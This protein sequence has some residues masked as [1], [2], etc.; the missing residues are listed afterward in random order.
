VAQAVFALAFITPLVA[1]KFLMA[2]MLPLGLLVAAPL[3]RLTETRPVP[4]LACLLLL[5]LPMGMG[6]GRAVTE[7]WPAAQPLTH[8]GAYLEPLDPAERGLCRWIA[9][10]TPKEALFV[11]SR[12]TVPPFG[13]RRLFVGLPQPAAPPGTHD[14]WGMP[15]ELILGG[16]TGADTERA[17]RRRQIALELLAPSAGPANGILERLRAEAGGMPVYVI[18]RD[19]SVAARMT[20]LGLRPVYR[21]P[22]EP[23]EPAVFLVTAPARS[24]R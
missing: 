15:P 21:E 16:V 12:L 18:A 22:R 19:D 4:A 24:S 14:G 5:F 13:R 9:E 8:R 11:D 6:M 23:G 10:R 17:E 2:S 20:G 7:G 1:Y 3:R